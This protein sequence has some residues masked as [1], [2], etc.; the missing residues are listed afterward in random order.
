MEHPVAVYDFN[1]PQG[2]IT[3][4]QMVK[5]LD[6]WGKKWVFQ[7]EKGD[8][9]YMHWQCRISLKKKRR[10]HDLARIWGD[11]IFPKRRLSPTVSANQFDWN[12]V[13]KVDTRVEGPWTSSDEKVYIPRQ[14]RE[15]EQLKPWQQT[16]INNIGVWDKRTINVVY[17]EHGGIG[18]STLIGYIRAHKLGM[19]LPLVKNYQDIM[20]M[21][22]NLPTHKFYTVDMPRSIKKE[23]LGD[24]WAGLETVKD[25][26]AYDDRYQF[27]QKVFDCPNIWVFTNNMPELAMLSQ[28]RWIIWV[29]QN[30][31]LVRWQRPGANK[32]PRLA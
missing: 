1:L 32:R 5:W 13:D 31:Q 25:G 11:T 21:V 22:C 4:E 9:G 3:Q 14:I 19:P 17:C 6:E 30:D 16:I 10:L 26:Y 29:V 8:S 2:D 7:L 12:Y 28:D 18:K 23:N 15:V 24:F 20:R 27:K